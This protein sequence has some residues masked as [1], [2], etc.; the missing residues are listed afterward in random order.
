MILVACVHLQRSG[1][2]LNN[3]DTDS[4]IKWVTGARVRYVRSALTSKNTKIHP[5]AT[6]EILVKV[7]ETAHAQPSSTSLA[8]RA[9]AKATSA[10]EH[11]TSKPPANKI[12]SKSA[13]LPQQMRETK[14]S[15]QW[16]G[17]TYGVT[18]VS[19]STLQ[20]Q[21]STTS[22]LTSTAT[23]IIPKRPA[24]WLLKTLGE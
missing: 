8:T 13:V 17:R 3:P 10:P 22:E 5:L 11:A 6:R 14:T 24:R 7:R 16:T 4:G 9:K 2:M 23:D 15:S 1:R 21:P 18:V 19:E 12:P 20:K